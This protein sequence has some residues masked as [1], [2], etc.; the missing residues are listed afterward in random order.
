MVLPVVSTPN[1]VHE[2][3]GP[4]PGDLGSDA[5]AFLAIL[6]TLL[7]LV[8]TGEEGSGNGLMPACSEC[9]RGYASGSRSRR[10]MVEARR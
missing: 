9:P 7:G 10:R 2:R 5:Q 1:G 4:R 8:P 6:A 3:A